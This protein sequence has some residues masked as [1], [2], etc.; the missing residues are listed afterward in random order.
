MKKTL[1]L[2]VAAIILV[3]SAMP[4][5]AVVSP[6]AS[7]EYKVIMH[8]PNGGSGSYTTKTDKDGKHATLTAHPK[9][10]YEF[11]KWVIEGDYV[12]ED[13]ELTDDVISVLLNSDIHVYPQFKKIGSKSS[14]TGSKI[15]VSQNTS[16]T[17]P[18]T[19][20]NTIYF[21]IALIAAAVLAFGA[22]GVKLAVSKK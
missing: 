6:T 3:L 19:G 18:K 10:G 17:S 13:G 4:A 1:S 8:N 21:A 22:V 16:S 5:F 7:K 11:S 9:N 15:T 20:D 12:L 2:L 14:E